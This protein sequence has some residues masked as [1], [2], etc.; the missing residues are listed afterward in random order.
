MIT[1]WRY[2]TYELHCFT[3]PELV[4]IC[5]KTVDLEDMIQFGSMIEHLMELYSFTRLESVMM[6]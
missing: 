4:A 2:S 3:L 1:N 5:L 6:S